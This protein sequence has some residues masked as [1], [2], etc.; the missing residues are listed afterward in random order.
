MKI[1][2]VYFSFSGNNRVLAEHLVTRLDCDLSRVMEK[3]QRRLWRIF[4]D[5]IFKRRPAIEPLSHDIHS[6]DHIVF[7][8]PVW[9]GQL[10]HPM[11]SLAAGLAKPVAAY[12][13]ISLCGYRQPNQEQNLLRQLHD[14][15][16]SPPQAMTQLR[17][18]DLL[19]PEQQA[20]IKV[21]A[22]YHV[23][24]QDMDRFE[25]DIDTFLSQ[26]NP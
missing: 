4:A 24:I 10:A 3:K 9:G 7:V 18:C 16:G 11:Q 5:M 25:N 12:S 6:Y 17:V 20:D 8:A 15:L 2:V 22:K 21:I 26:I 23:Q 13:F 19:P 1:L 14:L